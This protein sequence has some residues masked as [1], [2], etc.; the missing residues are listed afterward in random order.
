[1]SNTPSNPDQDF[2]MKIGEILGRLNSL[3]IS[4]N[5]SIDTTDRGVAQVIQSVNVLSDHVLKIERAS[6]ERISSVEKE[7][8]NRILD[9]STRLTKLESEGNH[10][11]NNWT[12]AGTVVAIA[13]GLVS[14]VKTFLSWPIV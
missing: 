2:Y 11:K 12:M 1:M 4:T 6:L 13:M 7:L 8:G 3:E 10:K 5:K 9:N 14:M